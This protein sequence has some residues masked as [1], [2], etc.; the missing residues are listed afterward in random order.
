MA[1]CSLSVDAGVLAEALTGEEWGW[2]LGRGL[3][4]RDLGRIAE[5]WEG[6]RRMGGPLRMR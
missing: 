6:G 3:T 1:L 4:G 2:S 5:I